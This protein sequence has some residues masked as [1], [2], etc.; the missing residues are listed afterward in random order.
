MYWS[1]IVALSA[2]AVLASPCAI[3]ATLFNLSIS[4]QI[5]QTILSL[6]AVMKIENIWVTMG[7][8]F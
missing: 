4:Y 3:I 7:S 2:A 6:N 1:S 8:F 5:L